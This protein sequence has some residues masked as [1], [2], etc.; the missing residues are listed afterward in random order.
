MIFH[1]YIHNYNIYN[2]IKNYYKSQY[3]QILRTIRFVKEKNVKLRKSVLPNL[4]K[5]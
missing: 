5:E 1:L 2:Y 3:M 4:S